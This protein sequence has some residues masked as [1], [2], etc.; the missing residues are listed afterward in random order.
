M[1]LDP[2][3]LHHRAPHE[4]S[5]GK[6]EDPHPEA[7]QSISAI[8]SSPPVQPLGR[9]DPQVLCAS[10]HP[11]NLGILLLPPLSHQSNHHGQNQ[12]YIWESST[13][14]SKA[15]TAFEEPPDL[16]C[17]SPGATQGRPHFHFL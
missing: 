4:L 13:K 10:S 8:H 16:P 2:T 11:L 17:A 3:C 14:S 7:W 6:E 5:P 12:A 1:R 15:H 9:V